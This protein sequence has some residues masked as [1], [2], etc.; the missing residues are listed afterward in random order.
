MSARV[1]V[2]VRFT[3]SAYGACDLQRERLRRRVHSRTL[4]AAAIRV[5]SSDDL[6]TAVWATKLNLFAA[7]TP[8]AGFSLADIDVY[9]SVA[10]ACCSIS[11]VLCNYLYSY[12]SFIRF[13]NPPIAMTSPRNSICAV[14]FPISTTITANFFAFA[15]THHGVARA[16]PSPT[17]LL[18][19][20]HN[21]VSSTA[22]GSVVDS[23]FFGGGLTNGNRCDL[24]GRVQSWL[25][26]MLQGSPVPAWTSS[27]L[28]PTSSLSCLMTRCHSRDRSRVA[29]RE[30]CLVR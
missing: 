6:K 16:A 13:L 26:T 19:T 29:H 21:Q 27:T 28:I 22:S 17:I 5:S 30:L 7:A 2:H 1:C 14:L 24:R 11:S 4:L 25:L 12:N 9:D 3:G 23:I 20:L 10:N 8:G 18:P 15:A